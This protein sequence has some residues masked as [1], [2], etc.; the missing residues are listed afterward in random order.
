M[1]SLSFIGRS[2]T[3]RKIEK[4]F[5]ISKVTTILRFAG[6]IGNYAGCKL[7]NADIENNFERCFTYK[8]GRFP[9]VYYCLSWVGYSLLSGL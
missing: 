8:K 7:A 5:D 6:V 9:V 4:T 3:K 1:I 2:L